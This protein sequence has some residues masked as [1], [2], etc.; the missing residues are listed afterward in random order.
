MASYRARLC[1]IDPDFAS[2][3]GYD[4]AL[5]C[6]GHELCVSSVAG[7]AVWI[8]W[9]MILSGQFEAVLLPIMPGTFVAYSDPSMLMI[10]LNVC[11]LVVVAAGISLMVMIMIAAC[12]EHLLRGVTFLVCAA[13]LF[14][15]R[16]LS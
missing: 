1:R 9:S 12:V 6:A 4:D 2:L 3:R 16:V 11:L 7:G 10:F 14:I 5:I 13:L 15:D 8:F